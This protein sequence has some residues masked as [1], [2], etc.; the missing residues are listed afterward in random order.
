[1]PNATAACSVKR[2]PVFDISDGL[3]NFI[4]LIN[5]SFAGNKTIKT[6]GKA[7]A[8]LNFPNKRLDYD[9]KAPFA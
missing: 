3:F 6:N 8:Q 1:M 4:R 7:V 9:F 5:S 2:K